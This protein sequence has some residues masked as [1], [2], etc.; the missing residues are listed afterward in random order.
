MAIECARYSASNPSFEVVG[1][2]VGEM[3]GTVFIWTSDD[4]SIGRNL[5]VR[6]FV[7]LR[8]SLSGV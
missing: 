1:A 2:E 4:T 6:G 3:S 8:L 7:G 5:E